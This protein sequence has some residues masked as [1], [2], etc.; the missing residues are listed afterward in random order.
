MESEPIDWIQGPH[1]TAVAG[2]SEVLAYHTTT[3]ANTLNANITVFTRHGNMPR[4]LAQYRPN[5][6]T[7]L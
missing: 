7:S 2:M 4:L 6:T 1:Q 3:M 5:A